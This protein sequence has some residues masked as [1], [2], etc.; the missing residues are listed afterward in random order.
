MYK[1]LQPIEEIEKRI[2]LAGLGY[3]HDAGFKSAREY[4]A[5]A[6][7]GQAD[8]TDDQMLSY[9]ND[10]NEDTENTND[11][12]QGPLTDY[13]RVVAEAYVVPEDLERVRDFLNAERLREN[14]ERGLM[15]EVADYRC[16]A[17]KFN[18]ETRA[19]YELEQDPDTGHVI[20]S[21]ILS[22]RYV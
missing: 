22:N 19:I 3:I 12:A 9:R 18:F 21:F 4:C 2:R 11:S 20:V 8:I 15:F 5:Q 1:K 10:L 16:T 17:G 6:A 7:L 14:F 13:W